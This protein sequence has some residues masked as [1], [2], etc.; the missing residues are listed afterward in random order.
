MQQ[1]F[2][3]F[4]ENRLWTW[5][6]SR[7]SSPLSTSMG[8]QWRGWKASGFSV[9]T[10]LTI[11]N[12]PL[13]QTVLWSRCNSASSTS[14]GWRNLSCPLRPSQTF[15]DEQMRASCQA[16]SPPGTETAQLATVVISAQ[17]ITRGTMPALQ[18]TYST[19][20]G[21]PRRSSRTSTTRLPPGYS[22]LHLRGCW[23]IHNWSQKFTCT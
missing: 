20:T 22:T 7:G 8:P 2:L 19:F 14:G 16:V 10:S 6:N 15:I 17:R 9:Y 3:V 21:R 23:P 1:C 12:G 18:D 4:F 11:W 13:T 5:G